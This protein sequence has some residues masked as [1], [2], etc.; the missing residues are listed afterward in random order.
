MIIALC[1]A[2]FLALAIAV[3][4]DWR[5]GV[6]LCFVWLFLEG[7]V[8]RLLP[9]AP[10]QVMLVKDAILFITLVSFLI[11]M[12]RQKQGLWV[13]P[14]ATAIFI[15]V[16]VPVAQAFNPYTSFWVALAGLRSYIW[17]IPALWLGYHF[18]AD[19]KQVFKFSR[20]LVYV[21]P[22]IVA[23]A[24]VQDLFFESGHPLIRPIDKPYHSWQFAQRGIKLVPSLF[25][26]AE[27]HARFCFLLFMLG[28]GMLPLTVKRAG[29]RKWLLVAACLCAL[30][31]IFISGRRAAFYLSLLG[32]FLYGGGLV[33]SRY[34]RRFAAVP[35]SVS[36]L[37][38][39]SFG[40]ASRFLEK[41]AEY[42]SKSVAYVEERVLWMSKWAFQN[43]EAAGAFGFGTGTASQGILYVPGGKEI[44]LRN[45]N[46]AL[47]KGHIVGSLWA[48]SGPGKLLWELGVIGF[49]LYAF[50]GLLILWHIWRATLS[51]RTHANYPFLL[52]LAVYFSLM[53]VWFYKGAQIGGDAHTLVTSWFFL[54]VMFKVH[55]VDE[56]TICVAVCSH[57]KEENCAVVEK[58]QR[59]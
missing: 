3:L 16:A 41:K 25:D 24:L 31:S 43:W 8:R 30:F 59:L 55:Q 56:R 7:I 10:P 48:E 13:P 40:I 36:I 50:A 35:L 15:M 2:A 22:I 54:G 4:V 18:F 33:L 52:A 44:S 23:V 20:Y 26:T 29:A 49:L 53:V 1:A 5:R 28:L 34:H 47:S 38:I 45:R 27:R 19:E 39:S 21:A 6:I 51:A 17:Y 14:F 37:L 12:P 11:H 58:E 57:P 46:I 32:F 9:G 42:Y